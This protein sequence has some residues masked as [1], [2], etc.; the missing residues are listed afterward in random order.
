MENKVHVRLNCDVVLTDKLCFEVVRL[1]KW[2]YFDR[3]LIYIVT[4]IPNLK[5][6]FMLKKIVGKSYE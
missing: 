3:K 2:Q 5:I 4:T 1:N 6:N